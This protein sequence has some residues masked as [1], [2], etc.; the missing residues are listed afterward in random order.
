LKP[1]KEFGEET[2]RL[3]VIKCRFSRVSN[4]SNFSIEC[5]IN[6]NI[7]QDHAL[8]KTTK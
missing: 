3:R 1:T 6:S 2:R 7:G 5:E 4:Q 8:I